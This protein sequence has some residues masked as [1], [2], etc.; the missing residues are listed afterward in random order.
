MDFFNVEK[1]TVVFCFVLC[2]IV[3]N[4]TSKVFVKLD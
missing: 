2:T 4:L 3:T 1:L